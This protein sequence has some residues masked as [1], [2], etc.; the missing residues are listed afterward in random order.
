[1]KMCHDC[2]FRPGSEA[3]ADPWTGI[4]ARLHVLVGHPEDFRCHV[5]EGRCVG[6]QLATQRAPRHPLMIRAVVCFC[7][8][9]MRSRTVS[10]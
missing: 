2:A 7:F 9:S 8:G 5:E 1:M 4:K 6:A 10:A 3:S